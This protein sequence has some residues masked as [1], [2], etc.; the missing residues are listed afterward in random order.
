MSANKL[1]RTT[2]TIPADI[3]TSI[4]KIA[5]NGSCKSRNEFVTRALERELARHK[6]Q[7]IDAALAQ[8]A[9]DPEYQQTVKQ[10]N[11]E[12]AGAS[13]DALAAAEK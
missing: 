4:D 2:L 3:L 12:F 7:E 1:V 8:M 9:Q 6:R 13:W 5:S 11:A 10:M